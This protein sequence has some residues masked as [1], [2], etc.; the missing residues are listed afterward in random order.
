MTNTA[1]YTQS[2]ITLTGYAASL[3]PGSH[4]L[5]NLLDPGDTLNITVSPSYEIAG[6]S[7]AGYEVKIYEF[8]VLTGVETGGD[9]PDAGL[10]LEQ[11]YPNPFNPST[12]ISFVL[13]RESHVTL[14]IYDI[15][16]RYVNTVKDETMQEGHREAVWDGRDERGRGVDSGIYFYRL[17]AGGQSLMRKMVLLR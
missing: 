2:G 15:L 12:T 1:S 4:T 3:E 17:T 11:N 14:S 7:L 5:A 16:G 10:R 13:P 8:V 9:Q 6:L